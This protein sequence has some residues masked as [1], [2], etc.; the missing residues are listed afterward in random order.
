MPKLPSPARLARHAAWIGVF[1]SAQAQALECGRFDFPFC[2]NA[3]DK[4][5]QFAGGFNPR[6]PY[7]GF[8]GGDDCREQIGNRPGADRKPPVVLIHGNGDSAIGWDSPAP[9]RA[10]K[11]A[12]PSVYRELK[13]RGYSDCKIFGV[14]YLDAEERSLDNT[15][16]NF[17]QAKKYKIIWD[18]VQ[19]VK[20]YT[21]SEKVDIVGHS[22]GVSMTLASLDYYTDRKQ[23]A[24]DSVNKFVN[25][26]GGLHG[27][28][29][30]VWGITAYP[31]CQA[32]H[33]G[34]KDDFYQFGFFPDIASP[35]LPNRWTAPDGDHSLRRAPHRHPD[36]AFYTILAGS[37]DDIHCPR[38]LPTQFVLDCRRGPLFASDPNVRAQLDIGA[39]S[40]SPPPDWAT[41]VEKEIVD[42]FPRDLGGVG[43]FGARNY[44]GPIIWQMLRSECREAA[45]AGDYSG[46]Y[47]VVT[48]P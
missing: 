17:H 11:P 14:T 26:V 7:G 12:R 9:A 2:S 13:A 34:A 40:A 32:E 5:R 27:L 37:H 24:W 30:C 20:A 22:L 44:A 1:A 21:K 42:L 43:H 35:F 38:S 33:S 3:K 46:P 47:T 39:E 23:K 8:G 28:N 36:V 45:C 19:A 18:F 10:G 31:T 16:G 29:A 25:I 4:P 15:G 48:K 6:T 41:K